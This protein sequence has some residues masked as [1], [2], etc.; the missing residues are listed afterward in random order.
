MKH[1]SKIIALC[2]VLFVAGA[3]TLPTQFAPAEIHAASKVKISKTKAT[4]TVGKTMQLKIKGTKKKVTWSSNKKSVATVSKKGKVTAKKAGKATITAK[5]GKK[6]F[7]CSVT[8]KKAIPTYYSGMYRIGTDMPAGEYYLFSQSN[9][10]AYFEIDRDTS[11][12][13][14]SIIA[15][16][17]FN[18]NSI[19]TVSAGQYLKLDSCYA[20]PIAYARVSTAGEG[21]FKVGRDISAGEYKLL[22]TDAFGGYYEVAT[23]ALHD[24]DSIISNDNF[25]GT[26]YVSVQNGQYLKLS[27]CKIVR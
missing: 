20:I 25:E 2:M 12:S 27:G 21:M 8:V 9:Y 23:S 24:I 26:Q 22:S 11:G 18:Y 3:F 14:D 7:K 17:N 1:I 19:V 6:K 13:L 16:D 10:G 4:M 5:V 15:N